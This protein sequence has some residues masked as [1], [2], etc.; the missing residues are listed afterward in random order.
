MANTDRP[1]G[2]EPKGVVLRATEY[3][4]GSAIYPGDPVALGAD[5]K[6][7][8]SAGDAL[9]GVALD[10]AAAD[11]DTVR[12]ADHPDQ[13]FVIQ[14]DDASIA[15]ISSVGGN[16]DIVLGTADTTYR[17]STSELD[18]DTA[19][20]HTTGADNPLKLLALESRVDNAFGANADVVVK[21]NNHQ[22]AG[23]T[24]SAAV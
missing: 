20:A 14:A 11:G 6:V 15:D 13:K 18:G 19:D 2:L 23:G 16:F 21:L 12:V 7:D 1:R 9:I 22:L 3:V 17:K 24:G 8:R 10:Y 4:A 5:G